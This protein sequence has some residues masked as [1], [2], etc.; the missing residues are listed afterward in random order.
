MK[1]SILLKV[2]GGYLLIIIVL[3]ALFFV[4]SS[5]LIKN[6]YLDTLSRDLEH[7]GSSLKLKIIPFLDEERF[8]EMDAFVKTFG[9][10]IDTRIT[11]IDREGVVLADSEE[12]P[13][14]MENHRSRPEIS[15]AF[16]ARVGQSLRYSKTVKKEMLYV[17]LPIERKGKI[18]HVLRVSLFVEDINKLLSSLRTDIGKI[19]LIITLVSLM[20]ALVFSRTLTRPIKELSDASKRVAA[21]DFNTKVFL[22]NRDELRELAEG[23]NFMT[24][25]MKYLFTELSHQKEELNGILSSMEEG[26]LV[27]DKNGKILFCNDSFRKLTQTGFTEEKFYWEVLRESEFNDLVKIVME[28]KRSVAREIVFNQRILLCSAALLETGEEVFITFHDITEIK[29]VEKIKK[30]FVTNVSHELRTPLTAIKGFV[31]TLKEEVDDKYLGY[32]EIIKRHTDRLINIVKDLL[33]LS[34][35]E[36]KEVK[37]EVEDVNLKK[38]MENVL[39]IFEQKIKEK[40]LKM[41]FSAEDDIPIIKGDSFK[42]EQMLMNIVDNAVKYTEKGTISISLK[43]ADGKVSVEVEDTGIGIPEEQQPRIFERFYVIDKSRSRRL[44]GTGLGL[45]IVKH[46]VLMHNGEVRVEST[47]GKGTKFTVF[48]PA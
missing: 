46:I 9:K 27:L 23:F 8:E 21:G 5:H 15:T 47:P 10:E 3:T 13:A 33:F 48:L 2:F 36:E 45:S 16:R 6:F 4:F 31:E 18:S 41:E 38:L 29:R 24:E 28:E 37:L 30:D 17:G 26:L 11:V 20:G 42:L 32:V 22:K 34:E 39:R 19:I 43:K 44:G 35:V 12:D 7:L 1:R 14:V 40:D 25:R